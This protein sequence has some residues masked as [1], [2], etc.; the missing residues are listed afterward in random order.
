VATA[1]FGLYVHVP[2]CRSRCAYCGTYTE[3]GCEELA[4]PYVAALL[5]EWDLLATEGIR[6]ARPR[7]RTL[8]LGGGTPSLLPPRAL[9][10]LLGGLLGPAVPEGV[11]EITLEANPDSVTSERARAWAALGVGRVSLG[12]QSFDDAILRRLGRLHDAEGARRALTRLREAGFERLSLDLIYGIGPGTDRAYRASLEEALRWDPGH[13]SCYLLTV[14]EG[15]PLDGWV[16]SGAWRLPEEGEAA[17]Q[18]LWTRERLARAGYEAYEISNFARPGHRSRHN[19][20]YWDRRPYL[21]LGAGAHSFWAGWRW[22]NVPD[23]RAYLRAVLE[24]GRRPVRG[25]HRLAP[26]EEAEEIL[27]LGLRRAEGFRPGALRGLIPEPSWRN[28]LGVI[29][30]LEA[31]GLLER[32][33][34]RVRVR[35]RAVALT[36][37]IAVELA[38]ALEG[39]EAASVAGSGGRG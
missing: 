1:G 16:A 21:G 23:L 10:R 18:L 19:E 3:T 4:R 31:G 29:S 28:L 30:R 11:L 7:L 2:F 12:V 14:E 37:A 15:T 17:A 27:L 33:E 39:C 25:R 13:L 9:E 36:Q 20:G 35:P 22:H 34:G 6:P 32:V 24:E 8:Y 38:A 26:L 5:R